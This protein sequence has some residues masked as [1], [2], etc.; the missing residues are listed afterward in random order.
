[1]KPAPFVLA[2]LLLGCSTSKAPSAAP[3]PAA[4]DAPLQTVERASVY[5]ASGQ[6]SACEPPPAHCEKVE[7]DPDFLLRC[8]TAGLQVRQ[9]GCRMVCAG[10]MAKQEYYD[11]AGSQKPCAPE[12]EGCTPPET[13]ARFQDACDAGHHRL[14]RCGCEYLCNG[15]LGTA[16]PPE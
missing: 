6:R 9:C 13:T 3:P 10:R 8:R 12:T 1:V 4:A 5:D 11:A 16:P 14:V 2:L 15:R 7:R